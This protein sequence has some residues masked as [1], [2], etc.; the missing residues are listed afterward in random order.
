MYIFNAFVFFFSREV[1]ITFSKVVPPEVQILSVSLPICQH[2]IL[3][4]ILKYKFLNFM[5]LNFSFNASILISLSVHNSH[6]KAA[7]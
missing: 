4:F 7:A 6:Y 2:G 3:P 1:D 5:I